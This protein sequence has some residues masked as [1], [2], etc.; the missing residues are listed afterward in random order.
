MSPTYSV[1]PAPDGDDDDG[2]L[3]SDDLPEGVIEQA[4]SG[5]SD[6]GHSSDD[7]LGDRI[8]KLGDIIQNFCGNV[9]EELA[10]VNTTVQKNTEDILSIKDSVQKNTEDISSIKDGL[11]TCNTNM[12]LM[13]ENLA[14]LTEITSKQSKRIDRKYVSFSFFQ[15]L[16]MTLVRANLELE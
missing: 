11:T 6:S 1:P 8:D 16:G 9:L 7:N 2:N 12:S 4:P 10:K 5:G 3:F 14:L 13:I 15:K